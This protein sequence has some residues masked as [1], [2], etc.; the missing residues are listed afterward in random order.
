MKHVSCTAAAALLLAAAATALGQAPVVDGSRDASYGPPLWVNTQNPT[1]FADNA[2]G[3][4]P[5]SD[6]GSGLQLAI[7]NSNIAG[8]GTGCPDP[9]GAGVTTGIEIKI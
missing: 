9:N 8:V 6:F 2:P 7:N 4:F 3:N 5:C 1:S